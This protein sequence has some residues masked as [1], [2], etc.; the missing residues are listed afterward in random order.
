MCKLSVLI[1]FVI[2]ERTRTRSSC[3]A[4]GIECLLNATT[5]ERKCCSPN[6]CI[7]IEQTGKIGTC[8]NLP[9]ADC[10]KLQ[11]P[12]LQ[13]S[14]AYFGLADGEYEC[15]SEVTSWAPHRPIYKHIK[16]DRYIYWNARG[17]GWS[18]GPS[19]DGFW[20]YTSGSDE[21]EPW[22]ASWDRGVILECI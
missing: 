17:Y 15:I 14:N 5:E 21:E 20:F 19:Y 1:Y 2:L 22:Q 10:S 12:K 3:V 13:L 11:C 6:K 4:G 9:N 8:V 16:K 18:I 7:D